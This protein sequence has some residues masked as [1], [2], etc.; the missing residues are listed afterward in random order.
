MKT[1]VTLKYFVIDCLWKYFFFVSDSHHTPSSL[2]AVII[3]VVLRPFTQFQ[4]K[5]R[6]IKL[7]K[8]DKI[9]LAC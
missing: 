6:V 1:R 4:S 8:S 5:I 2:I 9:C 7:Q 3:L